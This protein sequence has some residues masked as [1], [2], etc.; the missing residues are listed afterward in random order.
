M[1]ADDRI[2]PAT[3]SDVVSISAVTKSGIRV[4]IS[5]PAGARVE[6]SQAAAQAVRDEV[7]RLADM[8][9]GMVQ[10]DD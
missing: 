1:S 4:A 6:F 8:V 10:D 7:S 3:L 2:R 5:F 9:E